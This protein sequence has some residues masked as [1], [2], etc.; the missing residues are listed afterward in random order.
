MVA[1]ALGGPRHGGEEPR[2]GG[3]RG[4]DG[5][6]PHDEPGRRARHLVEPERVGDEA[7]G[8]AIEPGLVERGD[9]GDVEQREGEA[10]GE[11]ELGGVGR[12]RHRAQRQHR[13]IAAPE[14]PHVGG[15]RER[16]G[17]LGVV[18]VAHEP[19]ACPD[20]GEALLGQHLPGDGSERLDHLAAA[21]RQAHQVA[22]AHQRG[23]QPGVDEDGVD[24]AGRDV[25]HGAAWRRHHL[26]GLPGLEGPLQLAQRRLAQP[27]R[28]RPHLGVL[29]RHVGRGKGA[30]VGDGERERLLGEGPDGGGLVGPGGHQAAGVDEPQVGDHHLHAGHRSAAADT[31]EQ[32]RS[33]TRGTRPWT[34]NA[35]PRWPS[36]GSSML[37]T[38]PRSSVSREWP[39]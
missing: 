2:R 20:A 37:T 19:G 9:G 35:L 1:R 4:L 7:V 24:V 22:V 11:G 17:D 30:P 16:R 13:R 34:T 33:S 26:V 36:A 15:G 6:V 31:S 38:V 28:E 8:Q 10:V 25:E 18:A 3:R 23:E 29:P 14:H 39:G 12:Q 27:E 32:P 21:R 5:A